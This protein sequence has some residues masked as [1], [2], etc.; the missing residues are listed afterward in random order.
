MA[1]VSA[2]Q[3]ICGSTSC[4][5]VSWF[6][7]MAGLTMCGGSVSS[8][9][10]GGLSR[11]R[12]PAGPQLLLQHSRNVTARLNGT[13]ILN[14]RVRHIGG[15]QVSWGRGFE[16]LT[17]GLTRFADDRRFQPLH[18][19]YS[20]DW[21]L[22]ILSV[23][24]ADAGWYFCQVS[25]SPPVSHYLHLTVVE[26]RVEIVG[27]PDLYINRGS[28]ANLTCIIRDAHKKPENVRWTHDNK[29]VQFDQARAGVRV[30][31]VHEMN[32]TVSYFLIVRALPS[33]SGEY[34]CDPD[35]LEQVKVIVHVLNDDHPAAMQTSGHSGP[36]AGPGSALRLLTCLLLTLMWGL[37]A[38]ARHT[39][40]Q[41]GTNKQ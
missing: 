4:L 17:G 12:L 27:G 5:L 28:S 15:R 11:T 2:M 6:V 37:A 7:V 3:A 26:P 1:T 16:V 20:E 30:R 19:E 32:H 21:G 38:L 36:A 40:T 24:R 8:R 9:S 31:T 29:L 18:Q 22:R 25:T 39:Q 14:C 35:G 23:R 41:G 13:A 33:D 34:F 10:T